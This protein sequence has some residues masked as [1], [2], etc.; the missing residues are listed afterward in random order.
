MA[1]FD[2]V[3]FDAGN[4]LMWMDYALLASAM[5][6]DCDA[7]DAERVRL[8]EHRARPDL[9]RWLESA[10][11]TES[12]STFRT[13]VGLVLR[14]LGSTGEEAIDRAVAALLPRRRE[15]WTQPAPGAARVLGELCARGYSLGVVSNS[16][17][18]VASLLQGAGLAQYLG[19]IVDSSLVG[20]EKPDPAIFRFALE[21]LESHPARTLYVGDIPSVDH[22]AAQRAG[23]GFALLDPLG[24]RGD[25]SVLRVRALDGLLA[26]LPAL[27]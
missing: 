22:R 21:A 4:T 1:G 6:A 25:L 11:S 8:A 16:D 10:T 14:E 26:H 20:V 13:Y 17:G 3:L 15:I 2:T 12:A 27:R 7:A 23:M 24:L 9:D 19:V 5:L 18:S